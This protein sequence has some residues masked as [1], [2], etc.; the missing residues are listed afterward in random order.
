MPQGIRS[1]P[2]PKVSACTTPLHTPALSATARAAAPSTAGRAPGLRCSHPPL[3]ARAQLFRPASAWV[4]MLSSLCLNLRGG[5]VQGRGLESRIANPDEP[6]CYEG[7]PTAR[8]Q[9]KRLTQHRGSQPRPA[10]NLPYARPADQG[11]TR[12]PRPEQSRQPSK[13]SQGPTIKTPQ[14]CKQGKSH[15]TQPAARSPLTWPR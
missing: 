8:S 9:R 12:Q 1:W 2:A 10:P 5:N 3:A 13:G 6:S 15:P 11:A 7:R 14:P 4:M